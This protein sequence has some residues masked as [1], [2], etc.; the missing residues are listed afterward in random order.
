MYYLTEG[1][2]GLGRAPTC[3]EAGIVAQEETQT[4]AKGEEG[5][6]KRPLGSRMDRAWGPDT[7]RVWEGEETGVSL[8]F[9]S[10]KT[11][12]MMEGEAKWKIQEV[13]PGWSLE[14]QGE[15]QEADGFMG[16]GHSGE[17]SRAWRVVSEA[18]EA[19][20]MDGE[21]V[22]A[23]EGSRSGPETGCSRPQGTPHR[24]AGA[25]VSEAQHGLVSPLVPQ[26]LG[27]PSLPS[28]WGH[29]G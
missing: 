27:G 4:R 2:R 7:T 15:V 29:E 1:P 10:W 5:R 23:E 24:C 12:W 26:W 28:F 14:C 9:L 25:I 6:V 3:E 8:G 22:H 20:D 16:L 19:G 17:V 11:E 13:E 18:M 21:H